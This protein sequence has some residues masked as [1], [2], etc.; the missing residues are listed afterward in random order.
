[1]TMKSFFLVVALVAPACD[2]TCLRSMI[3]YDGQANG[4]TF[5]KLSS[6]QPQNGAVVSY[7]DVQTALRWAGPAS[8]GSGASC[9]RIAEK[10]HWTLTAWI[11]VDAR[12]SDE[13]CRNL[14][15][16]VPGPRDPQG[17]TAGDVGDEHGQLELAIRDQP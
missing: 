13:R 15:A 8:P 5:I 11:D 17:T 6:D 14:D 1:M 16:C 2:R 10:E 4:R 3:S 7:P 12:L 9:W